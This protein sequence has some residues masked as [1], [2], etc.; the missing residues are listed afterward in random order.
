MCCNSGIRCLMSGEDV[1][2]L[3]TRSDARDGWLSSVFERA[4]INGDGYLDEDESVTLLK[5]SNIKLL[6]F[7]LKY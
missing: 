5:V 6:T 4:D 2:S 7:I 3:R 1:E